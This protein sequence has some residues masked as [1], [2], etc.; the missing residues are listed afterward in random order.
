MRP[1]PSSSQTSIRV[2]SLTDRNG[3][4]IEIP[5]STAMSLDR[6]RLFSSQTPPPFSTTSNHPSVSHTASI[7]SPSPP[8]QSRMNLESLY[9]QDRNSGSL[10]DSQLLHPLNEDLSSSDGEE[11][12]FGVEEDDDAGQV[13]DEED[14]EE[15]DG[16]DDDDDD[17]DE[18]EEEEE[19]EDENEDDEDDEDEDDEEITDFV[20]NNSAEIVIMVSS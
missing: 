1:L 17:E 15:V 4:P 14:E 6:G 20:G 12:E 2:P 16:D 5:W 7:A 13:H 8:S 19:E 11:S 3:I 10:N 18:D 9:D